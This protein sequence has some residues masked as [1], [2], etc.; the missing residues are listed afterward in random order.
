MEPTII[1]DSNGN[2][3][4]TVTP[5]GEGLVLITSQQLLD[6][7]AILALI[8]TLTTEIPPPVDQSTLRDESDPLV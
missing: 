5:A 3:V 8:K 7:T 1:A 2:P 4:V 6:R